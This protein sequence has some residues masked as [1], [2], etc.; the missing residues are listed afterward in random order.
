MR[1]QF[2]VHNM[3]Y[4]YPFN[5][6]ATASS[7]SYAQSAVSASVA[8]SPSITV[9]TASFASIAIIAGA[10]G[11]SGSAAGGCGAA[12]AG[13]AGASGS[14]GPQGDSA[15]S[16]PA[17]SR[18]CESLTKAGYSIVCIEI[19]SGSDAAHT[20]CPSKTNGT[21]TIQ[22]NVTT[23]TTTTTTTAPPCAL[24]GEAC[25]F[26]ADCCSNNCLGDNTCGDAE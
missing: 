26:P 8:S 14:A 25:V 11:P 23:T 6:P 18:E 4:Y 2:H 3:T 22:T 19:L 17:G 7:S 13:P 24:F 15:T 1:Q 20:I 16:C 10:Q 9:A 12:P 5:V 21:V